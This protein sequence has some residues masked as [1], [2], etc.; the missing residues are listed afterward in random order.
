M[1]GESWGPGYDHIP[2]AVTKTYFDH[3]CPSM[4]ELDQHQVHSGIP[5][6]GDTE[7]IIGAWAKAT[8][9]V[10]D[11]CLQTQKSS[12]QIFDHW[13][14]VFSY[15]SFL[16]KARAPAV[17]DRLYADRTFGVPGSLASIWH[18]LISTPL[19]TRFAWSSLIELAFD[20]NRDVFLPPS[21]LSSTPYLSSLPYN[22]SALITN[23]ARYPSIPGLMAI[24]V[25]R[26]DYAKH[27]AFLASVGDPFVSINSFPSFPDAALGKFGSQWRGTPAEVAAHRR[28]C[29]PSIPEIVAKVLAVRATAAGAG[30]RR[31]HIMT[32]GRLPYIANLK[33]AL[34]EAA[35]WDAI[36][37]SRDLVLNW[38]QKFVAQAVDVLVAQRAQV[39]IGNG[40]S[41]HLAGSGWQAD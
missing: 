6:D 41:L 14:C 28:R 26:G 5:H 22:T 20:A 27:C 2:P 7:A 23:A 16:L 18:D 39:L 36:S 4:S 25:R 9:R 11:P 31:L 8:D 35:E 34:W 40:V 17:A 37:S 29:H 10:K 38:E 15:P 24:H 19:I 30:V 3:I 33:R 12:G 13:G 32:N 21:L 1:V